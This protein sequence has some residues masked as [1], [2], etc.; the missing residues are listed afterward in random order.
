MTLGDAATSH[1][2]A[3]LGDRLL[4]SDLFVGGDV[5]GQTL[6]AVTS[7]AVAG[8][9]TE[10]G[11]PA[12]FEDDVVALGGRCG[13]AAGEGDAAADDGASKK[14]AAAADDAAFR[15]FCGYCGWSAAQL[16][17]EV[18][19]GV[20]F[21]ARP[22][23]DDAAAVGLAGASSDSA[24]ADAWRAALAGLSEDHRALAGLAAAHTAAVEA[25]AGVGVGVDD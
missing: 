6:T 18:E 15:I 20:W 9:G 4:K 14:D 10:G 12:W 3:R 11:A 8:P 7:G 24:G 22:E 25:L 16:Q 5:S 23:R 13:D 2:A 1:G 21:L 19:R 17:N